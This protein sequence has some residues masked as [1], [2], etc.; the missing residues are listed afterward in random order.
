MAISLGIC[1]IFRQTQLDELV[2]IMRPDALLFR[3]ITHSIHVVFII[4]NEVLNR[5]CVR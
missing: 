2:T 3:I 5:T 1:P 4:I